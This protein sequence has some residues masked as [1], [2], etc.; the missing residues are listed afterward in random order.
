MGVEP[1]ISAFHNWK[2]QLVCGICELHGRNFTGSNVP[3]EGHLAYSG[4]RWQFPLFCYFPDNGKSDRN[5]GSN[6]AG[7]VFDNSFSGQQDGTSE[8]VGNSV[9]VSTGTGFFTP[10][11]SDRKGNYQDTGKIGKSHIL[12]QY[13][14]CAADYDRNFGC[15]FKEQD[16]G[17]GCF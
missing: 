12:Q 11:G 16:M 15:S 7:T 10:V 4:R 17:K 5:F 6:G 1:A 8:G 2:Q 9:F 3:G 14:V 13:L